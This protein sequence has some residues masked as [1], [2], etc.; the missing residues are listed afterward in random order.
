MP[1]IFHNIYSLRIN[2]KNIYI[3]PYFLQKAKKSYNLLKL[4][5]TRKLISNLYTHSYKQCN[6]KDMPIIKKK[7]HLLC[8]WKKLLNLQVY[9]TYVNLHIRV[10]VYELFHLFSLKI[11]SSSL[12]S[13]TKNLA[14][15]QQLSVYYLNNLC[16]Y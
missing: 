7:P 5:V 10:C 3:L 16:I 15:F 1:T 6:I 9:V 13:F 8:H 2:L 11:N 4:S 12:A 14:T